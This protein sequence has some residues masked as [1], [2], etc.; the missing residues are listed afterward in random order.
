MSEV[1]I[2]AKAMENTE[3]KREIRP[4]FTIHSTPFEVSEFTKAEPISHLP[5]AH[6]FAIDFLIS[7]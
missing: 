6:A 2:Q 5:P 7:A 1:G 3:L 4:P